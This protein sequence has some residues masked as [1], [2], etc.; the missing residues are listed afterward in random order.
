MKL[1]RQHQ[2]FFLFHRQFYQPDI[3][4]G[5]SVY[6]KY[7]QRNFQRPRDQQLD[8]VESKSFLKNEHK[9]GILSTLYPCTGVF[10]RADAGSDIHVNSPFGCQMFLGVFSKLTT[11]SRQ[12]YLSWIYFCEENWKNVCGVQWRRREYK[13][14]KES[15]NNFG[16]GSLMIVEIE[17]KFSNSKIYSSGSVLVHNFRN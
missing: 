9:F 10:R 11:S 16:K 13:P 17:L 7:L 15:K 2:S 4:K 12:I 6:L 14:G 1:T 5:Q 3:Q 8:V